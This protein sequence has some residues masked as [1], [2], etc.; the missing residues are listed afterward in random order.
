[1]IVDQALID[2]IVANVLE[3]LQPATPRAVMKAAPIQNATAVALP[4]AVITADILSAAV[5]PGQ[6]V[7]IGTKSLLTPSAKDWLRQHQ[8]DWRRG[9]TTDSGKGTMS[10][11]LRGQLLLSTV[12]TTVRGAADSVFRALSNWQ[13]QIGGSAK[14]VVETAIRSITAAECHRVL[15]TSRDAE[16]VACLA[17]RHASV[18]AAVA[19][20]ADHVRRMDARLSPNVIVIDPTERSFVELRNLF[21]ACAML[22]TPKKAQG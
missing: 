15:I 17:N 16:L 11:S 20:S 2:R 9:S 3:Q 1:L 6:T 8:I 19:M 13:R 10:P 18:R 21:R 12:N 14:E 7:Q 4:D 22:G 5:K